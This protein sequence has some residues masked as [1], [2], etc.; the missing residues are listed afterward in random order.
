MCAFC[1]QLKEIRLQAEKFM[2]V[3]YMDVFLRYNMC[4][5]HAE[6]ASNEL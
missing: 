3:H 6:T 5:R 4:S 2:L 1:A